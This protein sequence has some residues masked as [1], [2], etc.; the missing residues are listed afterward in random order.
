MFKKLGIRGS[1]DSENF[2]KLRTEAYEQN[3]R[4]AKDFAHL[5]S[6][7]YQTGDN[8]GRDMLVGIYY[9]LQYFNKVASQ[10]KKKKGLL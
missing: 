5:P 3:Q 1:F 9:S 2:Q 8:R 7:S 6:S 4:T 10:E